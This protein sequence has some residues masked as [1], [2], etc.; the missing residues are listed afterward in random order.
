MEPIVVSK[1]IIMG[2]KVAVFI[3]RLW[4]R[5]LRRT[6]MARGYD[7]RKRSWRKVRVVRK[8]FDMDVIVYLIG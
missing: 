1:V 5:R 3:R 6:A 4:N 7:Q 8:I 2:R